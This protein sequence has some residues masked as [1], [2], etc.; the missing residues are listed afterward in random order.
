MAS[1]H[2][3]GSI[4]IYRHFIPL[5][6]SF[7]ACAALRWPLVFIHIIIKFAPCSVCALYVVTLP[8]K[9]MW[10]M[11]HFGIHL[12][13]I[14][15]THKI[16]KCQLFFRL[17]FVFFFF[18]FSI[19]LSLHTQFI[20][21]I[22]C[23][24]H[25]SLASSLLIISPKCFCLTWSCAAICSRYAYGLSTSTVDIECNEFCA[26]FLWLLV[27]LARTHAHCIPRRWWA[28]STEHRERCDHLWCVN[29]Q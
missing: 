8:S 20:I 15:S 7:S 16:V 6:M 18:S 1:T 4:D 24:G 12:I 23:A 22:L 11:W 14:R 5:Y 13:D 10:V 27:G 26:N 25:S 21:Y 3:V 29:L 9:W 17:R 28:V 19:S 2:R